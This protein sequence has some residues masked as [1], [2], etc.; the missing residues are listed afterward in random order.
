MR[1]PAGSNGV[2]RSGVDGGEAAAIAATFELG[3]VVAEPTLAAR[4]A[5]GFIWKLTTTR[6]AFAVKRLQPWVLDERLP[7]DVTVQVAAA[8]A[9][10]PLPRPVL[11]PDGAAMADRSRVYEWAAVD[12]P[13]EAPITTA[14]AR[15]LGDILGRLHALAIEPPQPIDDW[16]TT[17]PSHEQWLDLLERGRAVGAPWT[18]WLA[19]ELSFLDEVGA[20]A[21]EQPTGDAIT[22]HRDFAPGNVL[23]SAADGTPVVLDWE[24]AG[25]MTADAEVAFTAVLW[26]VDGDH[27]QRAAAV[28]LREAYDS[29]NGAAVTLTPASFGVS[30]MTH[31]NFLKVNCDQSLDH[32]HHTPFTDDWIE[33]LQPSRLRRRLVGIEEL[34]TLLT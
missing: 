2:Q 25:A 17:P 3:D 20:R 12:R 23:P 13:Y 6:G 16:Y 19:D 22:C 27:V 24:N 32:E 28:A 26:T 8:D 11:T 9:G 18:A 31:L 21:A 5:N 33:Q 30:L 15:T 34:I 10:I 14:L 29:S 4:G 1:W 7:F